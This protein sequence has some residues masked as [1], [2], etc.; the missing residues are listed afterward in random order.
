MDIFEADDNSRFVANIL[1]PL[2]KQMPGIIKIYW[3]LLR[4]NCYEKWK[5]FPSLNV[6]ILTGAF[7]AIQDFRN[8]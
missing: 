5:T 2:E 8:K 6:I 7:N 4:I 3:I 1:N